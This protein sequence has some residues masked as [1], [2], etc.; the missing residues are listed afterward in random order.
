MAVI[1][2]YKIKETYTIAR[3]SLIL[4]TPDTIENYRTKNDDKL[5]QLAIKMADIDFKE[6]GRKMIQ[7]GKNNVEKPIKVKE[8]EIIKA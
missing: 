1:K 4:L 6:Y 7:L 2:F 3:N 5:F 8:E